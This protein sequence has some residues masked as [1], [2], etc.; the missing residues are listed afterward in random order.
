[1]HLVPSHAPPELE[2]DTVIVTRHVGA[3]AW[4]AKHGITGEVT[5]RITS[6]AQIAGKRI[7]GNVPLHLAAHAREVCTIVLPALPPEWRNKELSAD[8]MEQAGAKLATYVVR[9][10]C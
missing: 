8:E 10:V 4:L 1:M 2:P 9:R 6:P 5:L 3:V 7:I